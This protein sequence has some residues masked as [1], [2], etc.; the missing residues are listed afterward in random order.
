MT[1]LFSSAKV[2]SYLTMIGTEFY[3]EIHLNKLL[4][5][6]CFLK[7]HLLSEFVSNLNASISYKKKY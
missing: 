7:P 1:R 4:K 5:D 2:N 6:L 3:S